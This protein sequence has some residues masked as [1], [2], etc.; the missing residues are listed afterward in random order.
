MGEKKGFVV[1]HS[2]RECFE[3]LSDEEVGILFK[4]MLSYDS[5]SISYVYGSASISDVY[6]SATISYVYGSASISE[7]KGKAVVANSP[8][9][10]WQK[11]SDLILSENATFK[12]NIGKVIYQSGDYKLVSVN[13]GTALK[14]RAEQ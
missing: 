9:S 2:Y 13:G 8:Y 14:A 12:D 3:D 4:A 11:Q 10:K 7:V 1:Y 6:D 5:A